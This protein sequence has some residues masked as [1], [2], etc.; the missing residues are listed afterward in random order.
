MKPVKVFL[1]NINLLNILL[2]GISIFLFFSLDYPLLNKKIK[3]GILE[4]KEALLQNEGKNTAAG[5][6]YPDFASVFENNLFHPGRK[7]PPE[8]KDGKA[9]IPRPDLILYGTLIT[10]DL[11]IAYIEDRK[12]AHS[13]SGRGKRQTQLKMGE[14]ISGYILKEVE[15]NRI[16]LVKGEER[17]I[18]VLDDK[19]K[20]RATEPSVPSAYKTT[21]SSM[22]S[23]PPAFTSAKPVP[24]AV[25][26][27]P[28]INK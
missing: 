7:I 27:S 19:E 20:K 8:N 22:P 21:S 23:S 17:I 10:D 9:A 18:V 2:I 28:S 5:I 24:A 16:V 15:P 4:N 1:I 25:S 12:I 13:T 3:A 26:P 11:R 6:A 14:G